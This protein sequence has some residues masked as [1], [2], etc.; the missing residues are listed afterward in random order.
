MKTC[1][2]CETAK[3]DE[4]FFVRIRGGFQAWCRDCKSTYD[5]LRRASHKK[6]GKCISCERPAEAGKAKCAQCL[7]YAKDWRIK[8][9]EHIRVQRQ[10]NRRRLKLSV[11]EAYGGP[12]CSCCGEIEI[13]FLTIDHLN[14]DGA[15]HR[16][17]VSGGKLYDWLRRNKFPPGYGVLCMNCNFAKGHFGVCPH[18][19]KLKKVG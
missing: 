17:T 5:K 4:D 6:T 9:L 19:R 1:P 7:T 12:I 3:P 10:Q 18:Q 11:F 14:N 8:N 13:D 15:E 16:K 2:K